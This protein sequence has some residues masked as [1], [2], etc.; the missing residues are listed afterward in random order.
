[1]KFTKVSKLLAL[2]LSSSIVPSSYGVY[3]ENIPQ[4]DRFL[5]SKSNMDNNHHLAIA[6]ASS[7]FSSTVAAIHPQK[8]EGEK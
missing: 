8:S 5:T 2:A 4:S 6:A 3:G 1:M 7:P